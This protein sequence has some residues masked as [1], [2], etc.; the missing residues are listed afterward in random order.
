MLKQREVL[1]D[2]CTLKSQFSNGDCGSRLTLM[3][4]AH[5]YFELFPCCHFRFLSCIY[6][7]ERIIGLS[8]QIKS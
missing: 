8:I 3:D 5:F 2:I 4:A 7:L 1:L 6:R